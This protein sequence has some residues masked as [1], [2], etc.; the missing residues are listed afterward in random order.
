MVNRAELPPGRQPVTLDHWRE[1]VLEKSILPL[2]GGRIHLKLRNA[3][4]LKLNIDTFRFEVIDWGVSF[5]VTDMPGLPSLLSRRFL[6]LFSAAENDTISPAD[7]DAYLH[8]SDYVDFRQ[9]TIDRAPPRYLEG[10]M[11]TTSD[12][13][14]VEWH[15]GRRERLPPDVARSLGDLKKGDHFSAWVKLGDEDRAQSIERVKLLPAEIREF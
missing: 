2:E 6:E 15:D 3:L 5:D 10:E 1:Y 7:R 9:F 8:I 12:Q 14:L 4:R 11:I 13:V